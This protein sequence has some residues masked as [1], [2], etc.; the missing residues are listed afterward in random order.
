MLNHR[1]ITTLEIPKQFVDEAVQFLQKHAKNKK[2]FCA[3]SGGIDSS[4]TY[5]LLNKAQIDVYPVFIDH[6]LMRIIR[7]M[8]ESD[9]IKEIFPDVNILDIRE[10]FLPKILGE[11]DAERKR[12]LFKKAYSDTI[13]KVIKE[14]NG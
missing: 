4:T 8:E 11:G 7:G 12:Q 10:E 6:G 14:E 1:L 5:L 9:H 13:S 2:V 3:L